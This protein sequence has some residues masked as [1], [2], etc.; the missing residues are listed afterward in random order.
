MHHRFNKVAVIALSLLALTSL[1][2]CA[3]AGAPNA[4]KAVAGWEN[5]HDGLLI[6]N[7]Y[8]GDDHI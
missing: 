8:T 1:S 3:P 6:G 5:V 7:I 4:P 2:A